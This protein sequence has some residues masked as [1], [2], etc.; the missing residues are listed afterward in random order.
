MK[1][2]ILALGAVGILFSGY[3]ITGKFSDNYSELTN[4]LIKAVFILLFI[5]SFSACIYVIA[6]YFKNRKQS[7][8]RTIRQYYLQRGTR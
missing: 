4:Y 1:L 7:G 3:A 2:R 8:I 5:V 6:N